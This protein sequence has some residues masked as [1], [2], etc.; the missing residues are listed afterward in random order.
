M[1]RNIVINSSWSA[2]VISDNLVDAVNQVHKDSI[3][4]EE[5]YAFD[6]DLDICYAYKVKTNG[7]TL[8]EKEVPLS[9]FR[10]FNIIG[11]SKAIYINLIGRFINQLNN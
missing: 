1:K 4:D 5:I 3:K 6:T 7:Y 2:L 9:K 8:T 11:N 10:C